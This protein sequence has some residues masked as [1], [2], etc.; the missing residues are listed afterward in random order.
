MTV[1]QAIQLLNALLALGEAGIP[2]A[3]KVAHVVQRS[4]K[5]GNTTIPDADWQWVVGA[6][7]AADSN[8]T[9][10]IKNG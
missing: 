2:L 9:K 6:A 3:Q 5:A 4:V 10:A 7:N 1:L 8:L